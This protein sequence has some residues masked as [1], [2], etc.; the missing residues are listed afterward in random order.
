MNKKL[1]SVFKEMFEKTLSVE[2]ELIK[3]YASLSIPGFITFDGKDIEKGFLNQENLSSFIQDNSNKFKINI[4][5]YYK[6]IEDIQ[7]RNK[8][9]DAMKEFFEITEALYYNS[10]QT[11]QILLCICSA[12]RKIIFSINELLPSKPDDS[13]KETIELI[14]CALERMLGAN[15]YYEGCINDS[16]NTFFQKDLEKE[17]EKYQ[18]KKALLSVSYRQMYASSM[19]LLSQMSF[20][21]MIVFFLYQKVDEFFNG[22]EENKSSIEA[23]LKQLTRMNEMIIAN[24]QQVNRKLDTIKEN[25][26]ETNK[27]IENRNEAEK[28]QRLQVA[29]CA[30]DICQVFR[31]LYNL[32]FK[33]NTIE[34]YLRR[35]DDRLEKGKKINLPSYEDAMYYSRSNF[36]IWIKQ[37]FIPHY[38]EYRRIKVKNNK[39]PRRSSSDAAFDEAARQK[40]D[41]EDEEDDNY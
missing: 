13:D 31:D 11:T 10:E 1:D 21:S 38:L 34:K 14:K 40:Y 36:I 37:F 9:D 39:T 26:N 19:S 27:L 23:A 2:V 32:D 41:G 30:K 17:L 20:N 5:K 35:F 4:E 3:K 6:H 29:K 24:N 16:I 7:L 22:P 33:Q 28:P 15:E 25:Q 18:D 8:S 12:V